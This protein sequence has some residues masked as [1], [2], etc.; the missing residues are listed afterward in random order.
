MFNYD[1]NFHSVDEVT[2]DFYA[3]CMTGDAL[4]YYTGGHNIVTLDKPGPIY[5]VCP[6]PAHCAL[7]KLAINVVDPTAPPP[8]P[9]P[10]NNPNP[11]L[12]AGILPNLPK[13]P[14]NPPY[15]SSGLAIGINNQ[16]I[17]GFPLVLGLVLGVMR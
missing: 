10:V 13:D 16:L 5:F 15:N 12:P 3:N 4:D 1:S 6:T 14:L 9:P 8:P 11:R 2:Q 7:M 17:V